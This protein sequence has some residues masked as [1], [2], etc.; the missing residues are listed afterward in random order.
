MFRNICSESLNA[1][2]VELGGDQAGDV[3]RRY[4]L[5]TSAPYLSK[6]RKRIHRIALGLGHLLS[7]FV[8]NQ[9]VY[10]DIFIRRFPMMNV[11]IARRE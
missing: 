7:L 4:H 8:E 6:E 11:E 2:L 1:F 9:I 3:Y 10:Q 5:A